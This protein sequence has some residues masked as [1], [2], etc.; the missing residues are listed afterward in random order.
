MADPGR[1]TV[2]TVTDRGRSGITAV[3]ATATL[4]NAASYPEDGT[5]SPEESR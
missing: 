2:Q 1:C 5:E 4:T 3:A